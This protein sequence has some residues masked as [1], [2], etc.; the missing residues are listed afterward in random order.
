[1]PFPRTT[2]ARRTVTAADAAVSRWCLALLWLLAFFAVSASSAAADWVGDCRA[3]GFDPEQLACGTCRDVQIPPR[4]LDRCLRCCADWLDAENHRRIA[5][6]YRAAVLVD[7]SGGGPSASA[8]EIRTF[9]EEDWEGV[10]AAKGSDRLRRVIADESPSTARSHKS[11]S[12]LFAVTARPSLL[13]FFDEVAP[14]TITGDDDV[15]RL[16]DSAKESV[17]LDGLERADLKDMLMTLL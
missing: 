2:S 3:D 9:L 8:G 14:V 1:M 13:L 16:V 12:S 7:R 15:A 11:L 4:F 10:V 6:P 17:S 5:R